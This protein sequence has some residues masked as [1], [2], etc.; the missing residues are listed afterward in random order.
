M[1]LQK[2]S[3]IYLVILLVATSFPVNSAITVSIEH[4]KVPTESS[5]SKARYKFKQWKSFIK[6]IGAS[7]GIHYFDQSLM[8]NTLDH[9]SL[10]LSVPPILIN[11]ISL[12]QFYISVE[13]ASACNEIIAEEDGVEKY[14][15]AHFLGWLLATAA[16]K[17][18]DLMYGYS[19]N[20]NFAFSYKYS[21]NYL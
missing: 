4:S 18:L 17:P 15:W 10:G 3:K 12:A 20:Q 16:P 8:T 13:A 19:K 1:I 9:S 21:R 7:A 11:C 5:L 14:G 6:Q 2:F